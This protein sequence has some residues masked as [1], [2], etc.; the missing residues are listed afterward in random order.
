MSLRD[1]WA[2][3]WAGGVIDDLKKLLIDSSMIKPPSEF[4]SANVAS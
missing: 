4:D 1:A 2:S 3:A